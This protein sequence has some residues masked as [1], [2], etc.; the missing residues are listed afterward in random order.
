MGR[1]VGLGA[2]GSLGLKYG[3]GGSGLLDSRLRRVPLIGQAQALVRM[4]RIAFALVRAGIEKDLLV[5]YTGDVYGSRKD[6]DSS[7][8]P[9][10]D[11]GIHLSPFR[12]V[13]FTAAARYTSVVYSQAGVSASAAS[14]G[15]SVAMHA[16]L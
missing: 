11:F 6:Y 12:L 2:Y 14:W 3:G 10:V 1:Y 16:P 7:V 13:G 8:G 9:V 4:G 5:E 15:M